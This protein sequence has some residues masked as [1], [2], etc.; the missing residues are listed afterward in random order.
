MAAKAF[1][2]QIGA[3]EVKVKHETENG[4]PIDSPF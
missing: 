1:A 3:G 4:A 2:S